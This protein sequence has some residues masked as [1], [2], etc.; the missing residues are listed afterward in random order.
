MGTRHTELKDTADQPRTPDH[1]RQQLGKLPSLDAGSEKSLETEQAVLDKHDDDV[2]TLTVRLE[3]Q[4]RPT[5]PTR[6]LRIHASLSLENSR[7]QAGF[8]RIGDIAA[9][10]TDVDTSV[11]MQCQEETTDYKGDFAALYDELIS[12]DI[13]EGDELCV[14]HSALEVQ[15]SY[16]ASKLKG[17]L[18]TREALQELKLPKLDVPTFDGNLIH[19]KQFC[20]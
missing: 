2:A 11:L 16:I 17:R 12:K 10:D 9:M 20:D 6:L 8:K 7:I 19:C 13:A 14:A 4:L 18:V 3:T 15:L 1:A 5:T